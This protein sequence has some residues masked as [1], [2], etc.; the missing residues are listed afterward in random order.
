[1]KIEKGKALS[2][3]RVNKSLQVVTSNSKRIE[4]PQSEFSIYGALTHSGIPFEVSWILG[5][6]VFFAKLDNGIYSR[7]VAMQK[8]LTE[9]EIGDIFLATVS[10]VNEKSA[11]FKYCGCFFHCSMIEISTSHFKKASEYFSIGQKVNVK[12]ISKGS[13]TQYPEVSYKQAYPDSYE[14]YSR[15]DRC[16]AKV[17]S[18]NPQL[19]AYFMEVSPSVPGIMDLSS[20][21]NLSMQLSYGDKVLCSVKNSTQKGLRL[22]GKY[23]ISEED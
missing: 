11:F 23:V 21:P 2:W 9:M 6:N 1:M 10:F 20:S 22:F 12:L 13:K 8:L 14:N 3:N 17:V 18:F 19:E 5:K 16:I 15:G 7:K 4:I